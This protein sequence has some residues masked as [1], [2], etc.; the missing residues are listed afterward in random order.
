MQT[1][2]TQIH[3]LKCIKCGQIFETGEYY[4]GC[5]TCDKSGQPASLAPVYDNNL[6]YND[7]LPYPNK[8]LLEEDATNL[9]KDTRLSDYFSIENLFL[10]AE[11]SN[12]TGSHKDRMSKNVVLHALEL[13]IPGVIAASSGNA[14]VSLATYA[15][16]VGLKCIIVSTN[17]IGPYFKNKIELTGAELITTPEASDRWRIVS[18]YVDTG[19]WLPATNF[20]TP[21]VGSHPIGVQGYK[22]IAHEIYEELTAD[23]LPELILVPLSRGDLYWGIYNGFSD[24]MSLGLIESLPRL[25]AVEPIDRL[26]A[27]SFDKPYTSIF[28]GD[29]SHAPSIGGNTVTYQAVKALKA[30]N[31]FALTITKTEIVD[32]Q[33]CLAHLGYPL[34][35]ASAAAFS[36]LKKLKDSS[37]I[38]SQFRVLIV[39]TS[40]YFDL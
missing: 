39:A 32:M 36:A 20:V 23:H 3:N 16:H 10:K 4:K 6:F 37:L 31:G 17:D 9:I 15:A 27:V 28:D 5:P 13:G 21:P 38:T 12:P 22:A 40:S 7:R 2:R 26:N 34:E 8:N 35:S 29:Y 11:Y 19:G 14:G 1:I 18:D 30:S 25:I 33:R 24:L